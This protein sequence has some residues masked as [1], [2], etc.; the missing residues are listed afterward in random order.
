MLIDFNLTGQ[1]YPPAREVNRILRNESNR[2]LY[3]GLLNQEL[4]EQKQNVET[5]SDT[6]NWFAGVANF[7]AD[8]LAGRPPVITVRD[9]ER[10]QALVDH[11][12][13][14]RI[15]PQLVIDYIRFGDAVLRVR[16]VDDRAFI[17]PIDPSLWHPIFDEGTNDM[18]KGHLLTW[19]YTSNEKV[20][21]QNTA[22]YTSLHGT[23]TTN[24]YS[25][26]LTDKLRVI[27]FN[28]EDGEGKVLTYNLT[29]NTIGEIVESETFVMGNRSPI[30]HVAGNLTADR[31]FGKS[32]YDDLRPLVAAYNKRYTGIKHIIDQHTNPNLYGD[33]GSLVRRED[34]S[35]E[36]VV[37]GQFF[38][39][40]EGGITPGYLTWDGQL[41][42]NFDFLDKTSAQILSLAG[43]APQSYGLSGGAEGATQS[44]G[45]LRRWNA[46]QIAKS[47]KIR[48]DLT[49]ALRESVQAISDLFDYGEVDA[50]AITIDWDDFINDEVADD[51][52][53]K[54]YEVGLLS[55]RE[56]L[57]RIDKKPLSHYDDMESAD[58]YTDDKNGEEDADN[59]DNM[60]NEN[61]PNPPGN[62]EREDQ[63]ANGGS[64]DK[65]RE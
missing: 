23:K 57:S 40:R 5:D 3:D 53:I 64:R 51:K 54:M 61:D 58:E 41:Q 48:E 62:S 24:V 30:I 45:A 49:A 7:W 26:I 44:A 37:G 52:I 10:L 8:N 27:E 46:R 65:R 59:G 11:I 43:I 32:V 22:H 13:L 15:L 42:S 60:P 18:P 63:E 14:Q 38:P 39:V 9:N 28:M 31:Y 29:N 19:G 12:N 21:N 16:R 20:D 36:V 47:N 34:G 17:D 2:R 55:K 56:A 25:N 1:I 33:E 50:D 4:P 6:I 35:F